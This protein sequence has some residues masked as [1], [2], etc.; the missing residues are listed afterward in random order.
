MFVLFSFHCDGDDDDDDDDDDNNNDEEK[1]EN[2]EHTHWPIPERSL[3][4]FAFWQ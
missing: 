4:S 3:T 1:E 2:E